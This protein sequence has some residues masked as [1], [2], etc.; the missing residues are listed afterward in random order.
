MRKIF[1]SI[2]FLVC[3]L[4]TFVI[5]NKTAYSIDNTGYLGMSLPADFQAFSS[6]SPWNTPISRRP[7]I[8]P[9]SK[10]MIKNLKSKATVLKA[11]I[12]NWTIPLFVIDSAISPKRNVPTT[13]DAFNLTVD[14]DQNGIAEGI[15][16]P[17]G[18]WPDPK[19][20]GHMLL[21]DP[22]VR[23][24]WDFSTAKKLSDGSWTASRID[25]WELD[26]EGFRK[27]FSGDYWWTNG[28]TG[29]GMPLIAGLIRPEEIEAGEIKHALLFA[30]PI[31]RKAMTSSGKQQLC[32]PPASR[33]DGYGIGKEYI[34]EGARL[35]LDPNLNLDSLNLSP[36][37]KIIAKAMQK[38]GMYNGMNSSDFNIYFQNLGSDGGRWKDYNFFED[39]KNI[40]IDKFRVLKCNFVTKP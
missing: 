30:S 12:T 24:S 39:L 23:K 19:S 22:N 5:L 4:V 11:N 29:S 17:E 1:V 37:T 9:Y 15:P 35:Q 8:D 34:P 2:I 38:Y 26:G 21:I 13:S 6:T 25:I 10:N 20:D 16:L 28:A 33:T 14:P 31:N 36:A 7:A 32:S 3:V 18:V 27:P 40:P